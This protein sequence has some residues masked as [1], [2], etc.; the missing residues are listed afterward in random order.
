MKKL[1]HDLFFA[2]LAD[3]AD[4]PAQDEKQHAGDEDQNAGGFMCCRPARP[5]EFR[6]HK[7]AAERQ[8]PQFP[9]DGIAIG[10]LPSTRPTIKSWRP[11]SLNKMSVEFIAFSP[12]V[13]FLP[14]NIISYPKNS[15]KFSTNR[16]R[17]L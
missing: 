1:C 12:F 8:K 13:K 5:E 7:V 11:I 6:C 10:R 14:I 15:V 16:R 3:V 2:L 17:F 9:E 4:C